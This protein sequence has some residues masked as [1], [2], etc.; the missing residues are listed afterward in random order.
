MTNAEIISTNA[1]LAG[2]LEPVDTYPG[3]NAAGYQVKK[4]SKAVFQTKIWKPCK[5]KDP[6]SGEKEKKL[7]LVNASF[8][9]LSQVEKAN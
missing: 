6:K 5:I 7:I 4:G 9:S 2:I 3:W 1:A 8:F